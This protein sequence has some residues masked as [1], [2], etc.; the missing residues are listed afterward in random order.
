MA[1]AKNAS[2]ES[3]R[4]ILDAIE[5][6]GNKLPDPA[7]LFLIGALLVMVASHF[8]SPKL[9]DGFEVRFESETAP[10]DRNPDGK[11]DGYISYIARDVPVLDEAGNQ[12]ID[13][14][15]KPKFDK[16]RA[17][18]RVVTGDDGESEVHLV[19]DDLDRVVLGEDGEPV[20]LAESGWAVLVK[21]PVEVEGVEGEEPRQE[22]QPT[23]EVLLSTSLLTSNG[24]YWC[25]QSMEN[26]FLGFAPLGVV[27]LGML[28]IG[29]AEKSGLIAA[30][31]RMGMKN[32]PGKL[33]TPS[34]VF[35]GVMS[36][37]ASDAGYIVL[38]P[39]AAAI[40][41]A[42]GRSPL[43]GIAAVFAGVSAGFNAN[44]LLTSLEPLMSNLSTEAAKIVDPDREVAPTSNWYFLAASTVMITFAGWLTTALFVERRLE[45]KKPI[46]G[47]PN[48]AAANDP[49]MSE[50]LT[51]QEAKG[52][53]AALGTFAAAIMMF[54][55][56]V[57]VPGSP[58]NGMDGVFPRW[59]AVIVPLMF[60][61]FVM[62][63]IV[64][65]WFAGNTRSTKDIAK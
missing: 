9:P 44:L 62:P 57:F 31:L 18:T 12:A 19:I 58:L 10:K 49:S 39:L 5:W 21:S 1:D 36:S 42:A 52:A 28:G 7:F 65:G 8:T 50:E 60:F 37:L 20:D 54:G 41:L 53:I 59:V 6:I 25:L 2:P 14:D 47:G 46:D 26:N 61:A 51:S 38:P 17:S 16:Q 48:P 23:G 32:V 43:V 29:V 34:M 4:G 13:E 64:Y 33:L 30:L 3:S 27:L 11:V 45:R 15:G 55:V 35:L 56:L 22:L 63:G 40:Y 24:L